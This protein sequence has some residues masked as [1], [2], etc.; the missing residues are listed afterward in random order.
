MGAVEAPMQGTL[1]SDGSLERSAN[2]IMWSTMIHS[3]PFNRPCFAGYGSSGSKDE[4]TESQTALKRIEFNENIVAPLG[5][6]GLAISV[7][8]LA[9]RS[10]IRWAVIRFPN[11]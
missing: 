5:F 1:K 10:P 2:N 6:A 8:F 4:M 9:D 11:D 3:I 7:F